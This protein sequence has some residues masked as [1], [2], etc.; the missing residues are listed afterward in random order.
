M[1]SE[2]STLRSSTSRPTGIIIAPPAPCSSR[3]RTSSGNVGAAAQ[4]IELS[5]NTK[6]A[7][8]NTVRAPKR[9]AT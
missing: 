9:S 4:N 3:A 2:R 7:S 8:A 5:V 6:I 1:S